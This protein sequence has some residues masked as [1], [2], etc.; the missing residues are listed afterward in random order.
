MGRGRFSFIFFLQCM[1]ALRVGWM[2]IPSAIEDG[3]RKHAAQKL[4]RKSSSPA[5]EQVR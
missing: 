1:M 4:A 5:S 3:T 2:Q